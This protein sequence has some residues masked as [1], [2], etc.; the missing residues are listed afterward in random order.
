MLPTTQGEDDRFVI[1]IV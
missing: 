1:Y